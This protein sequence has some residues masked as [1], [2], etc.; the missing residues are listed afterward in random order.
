MQLHRFSVA[1][2]A[3]LVAA[4]CGHKSKSNATC[5]QTGCTSPQVC[6]S[7]TGGA[8]ACFNPVVVLGNVTELG[9]ATSLQDVRVVAL[10]QNRAPASGVA[11]TD[12]SGNYTLT[13][14][15]TRQAGGQPASVQVT[16]RADA[17]GYQS[18]PGG[19]RTS[20]PLD[21]STATYSSAN[22]RYEVS[23]GLANIGL[24]K[25]SSTANL[26]IISGTAQVPTSRV[27]ILVVAEPT[28]GAGLTAIASTDGSYVIFNV[29]AAS[30]SV[31]AYAVGVNY[32][33]VTVTVTS[34]NTATADLSSPSPTTAI[35]DG[36]LI[37]RSS[38]VTPSTTTP[39]G[40]ELVVASTYDATLDRGEAPPGLAMR[41]TSGN[42]YSF[43]GVPDGSYIVLA[44]FGI[45]GDVRDLSGIGGTAPVTV[46]IS[47]G[48]SASA[49]ASFAIVGAVV[50]TKIDGVTIGDT[51][52]VTTL[53][54]ATPT[55][56]WVKAPSYSSAADFEAIVYDAFGTNIWSATVP[57]S[58][59]TYTATF[60]TPPA[61]Q[62]LQ[63]GMYYQ[64]R[65]VALD[66]ATPTPNQLS[67]TEDL[68]GVFY[69][70]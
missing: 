54:S 43:A 38:A 12:A 19:V 51:G 68:K 28:G 26:G 23:G 13:I 15:V 49:S 5:V 66:G 56:E 57:N 24:I 3:A 9:T 52:A 44:A 25:L 17:Q 61:S 22:A 30:Y 2:V 16:L 70:P 29:P 39:I 4:G 34:G 21:L 47:G 53:T 11:T 18:F 50:L 31:D 45:D 59:S 67:Q 40:V 58:G 35:A 10:D 33:P 55:F 20:L 65:I 14:P 63:H 48:A 1:A 32:T 36:S 64:L 7:V 27:G 6:E 41:L 62:P 46:V 42:S 60:G 37:F 69:Y 8:P